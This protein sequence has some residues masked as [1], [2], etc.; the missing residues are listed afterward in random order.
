MK[1]YRD[2]TGKLHVIENDFEHLLPN[3][4][5]LISQQEAD[6]MLKPTLQG[7]DFQEKEKIKS[8]LML[9]DQQTIRA[10][11]EY[12]ASKA[13]APQILKDRETLAAQLRVKLK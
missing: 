8:D 5:V 1:Y 7:L 4:C 11:R 6:F 2:L 10:M 3:G 9:L 13:D 12:I